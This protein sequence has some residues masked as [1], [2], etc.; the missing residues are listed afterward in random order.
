MTRRE[1]L[2]AAL[3]GLGPL[4]RVVEAAGGGATASNPLFP[5]TIDSQVGGKRMR[6]VLTGTAMRTWWGLSVYAIGS[7]VQEGAKVRDAETLV[8]APVVKR[9]HLAFER[10]VD[11]SK[12]AESFREAIGM[13]HPAPAFATELARLERY[14]T[15]HSARRGD[16]IWLTYLPGAGLDCLLAG[17]P[18]VRIDNEGFAQ[19]AWE[20]YLGKKNLGTAIRTG[21]TS[22]L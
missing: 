3:V 2:A 1:L 22:R 5:A 6:L 10:D 20:V 21:L 7:Y 14:F 16:H 11:G 12:M 15:A 13:N 19:A 18:G 17:W 9:L 8:R 4:A